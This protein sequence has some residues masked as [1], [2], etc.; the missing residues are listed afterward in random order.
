M[1]RHSMFNVHSNSFVKKTHL[2]PYY[3]LRRVFARAVITTNE[4][5]K[6]KISELLKK[7]IVFFFLFLFMLADSWPA[8]WP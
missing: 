1:F 4:K 3:I 5:V 8:G 2:I 6:E 7:F